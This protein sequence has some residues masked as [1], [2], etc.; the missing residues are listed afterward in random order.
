[1]KTSRDC[2]YHSGAGKSTCHL[3]NNGRYIM[4]EHIRKLVYEDINRGLMRIPTLT[5]TYRS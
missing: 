4:W 2:V 3:W 5:R 1:M